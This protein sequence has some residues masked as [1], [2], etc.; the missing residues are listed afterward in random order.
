MGGGWRAFFTAM[1][2]SLSEITLVR[3]IGVGGFGEVWLALFMGEKWAVKRLQTVECRLPDEE[4][5]AMR[6]EVAAMEM[7]RHTHVMTLMAYSLADD[8]MFL[9]TEYMERGSLHDVLREGPSI[10]VRLEWARHIARGMNYLHYQ[11]PPILHGDLKSAN[12]LIS[13][14]NVARVA[15]FGL[16]KAVSSTRSRESRRVSIQWAA[17]ELFVDDTPRYTTACDTYSYGIVLWEIATGELPYAGLSAGVVAG[18]VAVGKRPP[19]PNDCHPLL[20]RLMT[21]AWSQ[22]AADRPSFAS[23]IERLD[24]AGGQFVCSERA[25]I[26]P[27]LYEPPKH[28]DM[29]ANLIDS[30]SENIKSDGRKS[31]AP[32]AVESSL[33]YYTALSTINVRV[34]S[35]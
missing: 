18:R 20:H 9:A 16:S 11:K 4:R 15:D 3:R 25:Q 26:V 14:H 5:A 8:G 32:A 35:I 30:K 2:V 27:D 29:R 17:P 23:I 21:D 19:V 28:H 1:E 33:R 24:D 7:L 34:P 12:V 13:A 22:I 10:D 6:R 31:D